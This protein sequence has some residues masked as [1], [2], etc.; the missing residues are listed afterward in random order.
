[1][2]LRWEWPVRRGFWSCGRS[3]E[4]TVKMAEGGGGKVKTIQSDSEFQKE[5]V[6]AAERLVVVD[7]FATW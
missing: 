4:L 7:F 5:L 1:M 6:L 2:L 3:H